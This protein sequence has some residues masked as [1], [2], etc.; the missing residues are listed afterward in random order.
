MIVVPLF[1][2]PLYYYEMKCICNICCEIY[3]D[4]NIAILILRILSFLSVSTVH[5]FHP[6]IF[7]PMPICIYIFKVG[8][9]KAAYSWDFFSLFFV[10]VLGPFRQSVF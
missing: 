9:S 10:L 6:F 8:F 7:I 2:W 4:I 5:L 3:F 1:N